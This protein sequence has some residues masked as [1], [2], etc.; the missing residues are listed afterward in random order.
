MDDRLERIGR[1]AAV[2]RGLEREGA[3][4]AAKL[5]RAAMLSELVRYAEQEGPAG[6]AVAGRIPGGAARRPPGG[7]AAG[8]GGAA[9]APPR[10]CAAPG[11][12][13]RS[14]TPRGSAS[15]GSAAT[16]SSAT[17]SRRRVPTARRR[18][19]RST[20]S[21]PCGTWRPRTG[22]RS[23]PRW[24]PGPVTWSRRS[25][26]A[27]TP[28]WRAS[29]RPGSGPR[30]RRWST[31][32]SAR[33]CSRCGSAAC[34]T[35]TG[36]TSPRRPSGRARTP[37]TRDPR[38]PDE[39]AS[40]IAGRVEALRRA[41]VTRLAGLDD[42]VVGPGRPASGVGPGHRAVA[43]GVLRPPRGVAP[44]PARRRRRRAPAGAQGPGLNRNGRPAWDRPSR[45]RRVR[46]SL[47]PAAWP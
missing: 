18:R 42:A 4:N 21:C 14:P 7:P 12:R 31:C 2:A 22:A 46:A 5:L 45:V 37:R 35:R 38:T 26:A 3:Y 36:P 34:S 30:A 17:T 24:R 10:G 11:T 16:R 47:R 32:C 41:T 15:A 28:R 27:T 29:R 6:G 44:R 8:H 33:S 43:G 39:P 25:P 1:Y 40:A 19:S 9:R 20:R 13:S 23:S